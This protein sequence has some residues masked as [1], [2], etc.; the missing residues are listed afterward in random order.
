MIM[1]E[2]KAQFER[3]A[4]KP[5]KLLNMYPHKVMWIHNSDTLI[6]SAKTT[7]L[8]FRCRWVRRGA[9]LVRK[10]AAGRPQPA[11]SSSK[12]SMPQEITPKDPRKEA[13]SIHPFRTAGSSS[14]YR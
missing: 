7:R 5:K 12:L 1:A 9:E 2:S 14:Q 10:A 6:R 13:T 11:N 8:R 4:P 3:I